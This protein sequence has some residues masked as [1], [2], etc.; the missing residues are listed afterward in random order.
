MEHLLFI[1]IITI[2]VSFG[3]YFKL[4]R[5]HGHSVKQTMYYALIMSIVFVLAYFIDLFLLKINIHVHFCL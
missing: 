3:A 5:Y 4:Y 2:I 1:F